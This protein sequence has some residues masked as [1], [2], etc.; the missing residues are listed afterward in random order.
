[1]EDAQN[2]L[3]LKVM[4]KI[5]FGLL[6]LSEIQGNSILALMTVIAGFQ[7]LLSVKI[8][9]IT[10]TIQLIITIMHLMA[11]LQFH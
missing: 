5:T 6:F 4:N 10:H 7:E 2:N 11:E 8:Y 1:M 3:I 9:G